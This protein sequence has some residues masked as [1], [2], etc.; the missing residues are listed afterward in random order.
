MTFYSFI[1]GIISIP[2]KL[3]YRIRVEGIE[4]IPQEGRVVV[5]SNHSN[6]LDPVILAV[7]LKRQIFFMAKKEM[8]E[9]KIFNYIFSKLGTFPVD[10]DG[11]D[12]SAIKHA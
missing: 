10:R 4:N 6:V 2:L 8:F 9:K 1:K 3:I 12:L 5:C 7:S 11:A